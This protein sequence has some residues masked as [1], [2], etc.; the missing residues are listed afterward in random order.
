MTASRAA[1]LAEVYSTSS[2]IVTAR[3]R[4]SRAGQVDGAGRP[5][6]IVLLTLH[7]APTA[8]AVGPIVAWT[9]TLRPLVTWRLPCQK[10]N[11]HASRCIQAP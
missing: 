5:V 2:A 3:A 7:T 6:R 1:Q 10:Q 8:C 4:L 9:R 11:L